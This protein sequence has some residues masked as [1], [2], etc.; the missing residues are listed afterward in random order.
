MNPKPGGPGGPHGPEMDYIKARHQPEV[1]EALHAAF[2]S[3]PPEQRNVVRWHFLDE[4]TGEKIAGLLGITPRKYIE[5]NNSS[6]HWIDIPKG[7]VKAAS[8]GAIITVVACRQG[9]CAE[10]GA[11]GVGRA[12]TTAVVRSIVLIIAANL[13][14]TILF[15]WTLAGA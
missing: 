2:V 10:G 6:V 3:L 14:Y 9:L 7:L 8:F 15:Y 1:K 13:C 4:M 12:T 11:L 5:I